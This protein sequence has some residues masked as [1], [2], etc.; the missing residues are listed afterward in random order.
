ME[1]SVLNLGTRISLGN[2]AMDKF[3]NQ[4]EVPNTTR[5]S[6]VYMMRLHGTKVISLTTGG[7]MDS[8]CEEC[9]LVEK[10]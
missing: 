4:N 5:N 9:L 8:K 2:P 3:A 10:D 7:L 6:W 1:A